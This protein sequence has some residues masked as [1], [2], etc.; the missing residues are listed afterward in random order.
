MVRR[1]SVPYCTVLYC[2]RKPFLELGRNNV[3]GNK[4]RNDTKVLKGGQ[5]IEISN[6]E[7]MRGDSS[8]ASSG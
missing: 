5:D 8:I 4:M 2:K 7:D 1:V 6:Q 3:D